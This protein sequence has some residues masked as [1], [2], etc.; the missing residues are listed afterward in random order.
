M[1]TVLCEDGEGPEVATGKSLRRRCGRRGVRMPCSG[2]DELAD[3]ADR[4]QYQESRCSRCHCRAWKSQA[5]WRRW[6]RRER[7]ADG[8]GVMALCGAG[9][10]AEEIVMDAAAF[11]GF[12]TRWTL[13]PP[14]AFP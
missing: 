6:R 14:R 5:R 2:V 10:D 11:T 8:D 13:S 7:P 12:R 4:G 3:A 1:R 9:G